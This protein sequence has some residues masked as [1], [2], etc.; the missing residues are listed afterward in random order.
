[1][2][3]ETEKV[4]LALGGEGGKEV[5]TQKSIFEMTIFWLLD[6]GESFRHQ[7]INSRKKQHRRKHR[8]TNNHVHIICSKCLWSDHILGEPFESHGQ[9]HCCHTHFLEFNFDFE[10][11]ENTL[12]H[13]HTHS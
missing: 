9:F 7:T 5:N 2:D 10:R 13:T 4:K 11:S 1:M 12:V 8:K 6:N 3:K